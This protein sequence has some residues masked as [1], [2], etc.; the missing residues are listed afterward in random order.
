MNQ[1]LYNYFM[2]YE[3]IFYRICKPFL[4]KPDDVLYIELL[5][6]DGTIISRI[7]F[8]DVYIDGIDGLDFNFNKVERDAG[9]FDVNFKFNNIDYEFIDVV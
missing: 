1:G 8:F 5:G 9:T 4:Y 6:E 3:T 7:K 2:L